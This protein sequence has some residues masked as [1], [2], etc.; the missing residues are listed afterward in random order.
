MEACHKA[1][2]GR[3]N[4]PK[5]QESEKT[6]HSSIQPYVLW[7][8]NKHECAS[9]SKKFSYARDTPARKL[10]T[11]PRLAL[12]SQTLACGFVVPG[13]SV[14]PRPAQ[15]MNQSQEVEIGYLAALLFE[16]HDA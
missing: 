12:V 13:L 9:N 6:E 16:D 2:V 11:V 5:T 14:S 15:T 3:L 4:Q 8:Q 7:R 10:N 1:V